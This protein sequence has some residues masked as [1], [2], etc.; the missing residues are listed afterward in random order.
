MVKSVLLVGGV[1]NTGKTTTLNTIS[2]KLK[3]N[4]YALI[5]SQNTGMQRKD[6]LYFLEGKDSKGKNVSIVINTAA[7]D[8]KSINNF[9]VFL[10]ENPCD[11]IITA[12]R[13]FGK[14]RNDI[15]D[16]I[17]KYI[18][19]DCFELEIPLAKITQRSSNKNTGMKWYENSVETLAE[20]ILKST[21]FSL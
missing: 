14:E 9:D 2:K 18:Q 21:P 3:K 16:V 1:P 11:I 10:Q 4:G 19:N 15:L 7:D 12:I 13:S 6:K 20:H 8:V 17:K 5:K